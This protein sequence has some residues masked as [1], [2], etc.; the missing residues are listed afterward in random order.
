[1]RAAVDTPR[2]IGHAL[3]LEGVEAVDE[4]QAVEH[5]HAAQ[6][7]EAH[8]GRNA[9]G[10]AAHCQGDDAAECG[11]RHGD[12]DHQGLDDRLQ[13]KIEQQKDDNQCHRHHDGHAR[14]GLLQVL[15]RAVV[16]DAVAR[17][18]LQLRLDG[19]VDIG[20]HRGHVAPSGVEA[21]ID[22]ARGPVARNL[23][24]PG[25][26]ADGGQ[27]AHGYLPSVGQVDGQPAQVVDALAVVVAEAQHHGK[28]LL[29]LKHLTRVAAGKGGA[30]ILVELLHV[31]AVLGQ[32]CAVVPHRNLRQARRAL[33]GHVLGAG[34]VGYDALKPAA[35]GVQRVEVLAIDLHCHILAYAGHQLVGAQ[36]HGLAEG[37]GDAGYPGQPSLNLGQQ[38]LLV[39]GTLP[40]AAVFLQDDETV[41]EVHAHRVVGHCRHADAPADGLHL[42]KLLEQHPLHLGLAVNGL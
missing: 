22:A 28:A 18:Q 3:V 33:H 14:G 37:A 26:V 27:F 24:R 6:H 13:G 4:H 19:L 11:Q 32:P 2:H 38:L 12:V 8:P 30:D 9:E 29:A 39:L 21:H 36:F 16:G 34:Y 31:K 15:E 1:M 5:G 40:F 41:G 7:D 25:L 42:G 17:R 23:H 10:H 35:D 20:H